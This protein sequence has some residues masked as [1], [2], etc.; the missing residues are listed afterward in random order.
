MPCEDNKSLAMSQ[1]CGPSALSSASL[2]ASGSSSSAVPSGANVQTV[3]ETSPPT[4]V[5]QTKTVSAP[6]APASTVTVTEKPPLSVSQQAPKPAESDV[7]VI[8]KTVV[9]P[10]KGIE[11]TPLCQRKD[12]DY[13]NPCMELKCELL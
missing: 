12:G 3:T 5:F 4:T 9:I 7:V 11:C 6:A 13:A 10:E 2:P 8:N 1:D